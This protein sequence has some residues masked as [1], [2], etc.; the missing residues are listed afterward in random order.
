MNASTHADLTEL[1]QRGVPDYSLRS[2]RTDFAPVREVAPNPALCQRIAEEK[3]CE[4]V[5]LIADFL[6][7]SDDVPEI[8]SYFDFIST[9]QLVQMLFGGRATQE[10]Y[11]AACLELRA[12]FI[13]EK[14]DFINQ[15]AA[16]IAQETS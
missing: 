9:P 15:K 14:Q 2:M 4:D 11:E 5:E 10:Q 16:Q 3:V 8:S 13:A 7:G 6:G 12:R 1:V